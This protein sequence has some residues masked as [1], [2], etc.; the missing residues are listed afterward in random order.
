MGVVQISAGVENSTDFSWSTGLPTEA[1]LCLL[2]AAAAGIRVLCNGL[3][4]ASI[5]LFP[6]PRKWKLAFMK[7][8]NPHAHYIYNKTPVQLILR[9]IVVVVQCTYRMY[10][11]ADTQQV[12]GRLVYRDGSRLPRI[13]Q[14]SG[15]FHRVYSQN[16][17]STARGDI[18]SWGPYR[19]FSMKNLG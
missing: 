9:Y 2:A 1:V 13:R 16:Y 15:C 4:L 7:I 14:Q 19:T 12:Y 8:I 6:P 5:L 10:Y 18:R 11:I 3:C 17:I